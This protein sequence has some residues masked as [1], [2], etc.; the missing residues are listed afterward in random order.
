[1]CDQVLR[2]LRG[3]FLCAFNTAFGRG[4]G[5]SVHDRTSGG[6]A[7]NTDELDGKKLCEADRSAEHS[8]ARAFRF[9]SASSTSPFRSFPSASTHSKCG[10][11]KLS[12]RNQRDEPKP[13][14]RAKCLTEFATNSIFEPDV[15][16]RL[17]GI[18]TATYS[19][20]GRRLV[21]FWQQGSSTQQPTFE[22]ADTAARDTLGDFTEIV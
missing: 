3:G 15:C 14:K 4:T 11:R 22:H 21:L 19:F 6:L 17:Q 13:G 7:Q 9:S 1:M 18:G 20:T 8:R 16:L 5:Q 12:A 2:D 10:S